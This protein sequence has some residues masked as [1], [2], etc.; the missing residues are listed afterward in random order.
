MQSTRHKSAPW[1]WCLLAAALLVPAV[2]RAQVG[3]TT[4]IIT[5][6]VKGPGDQPIVGA[7]V[8][9][10][11]IDTHI[12][13]SH[14]TN[15]DGR[16]TVVF[17]DGGGQYRVEIR[18]VGYTPSEA[19]I[20]RQ[21]DEDRLVANIQLSSTVHTLATVSRQAVGTRGPTPPTRAAPG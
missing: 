15:S 19:L 8:T 12:S 2:V 18:A 7:T 6:Q 11:S 10:T 9:V 16:Y 17:P 14:T 4:D 1:G 5:G 21:A 20:Q 3:S 13:R